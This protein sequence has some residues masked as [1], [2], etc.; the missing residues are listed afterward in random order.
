[1][2]IVARVTLVREQRRSRVQPGAYAYRPGR[3]SVGQSLC[4]RNSARATG[5]GKEERVTLGVDLD[6][7]LRD[8]GIADRSAVL[9]EGIGVRIGAQ[10]VEQL[11]RTLDVGE[12]KRDRA[13]REIAAHQV[14]SSSAKTTASSRERVRSTARPASKG[15]PAPSSRLHDGRHS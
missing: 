15:R 11:R 7:A 10:L 2:D 5:E 4:G 13:R 1:M 8:R 3:E 6:A 14:V 9:R 12:E